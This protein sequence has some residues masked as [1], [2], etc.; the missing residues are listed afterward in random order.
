MPSNRF[1]IASTK[2]LII[3]QRVPFY[4]LM[5]LVGPSILFSFA[6]GFGPDSYQ[7]W[8]DR[9]W[10]NTTN[11]YL[12]SQIP[13]HS[14][15]GPLWRD[16][17]LCGNIWLT[18]L[19]TS[20]LALDIVLGR[21]LHL[22]PFGI[23]VA[24]NLTLYFVAV[25]SMYA[26]LRR[27]L[28]LSMESA[29]AAAAVFGATACWGFA[30]YGVPDL[31]MGVAWL[32][33]LLT[34]MHVVNEASNKT[35]LYP[36]AGLAVLFFVSA[37]HTNMSTQPILVFLLV[38]YA[39]FIFASIRTKL[40]V[41]FG[42][43]LGL[44]LYSPY[45]WAILEAASISQRLHGAGFVTPTLFNPEQWLLQAR[46]MLS[47]AIVG[48]N[49][50]GIY[51]VV[52]LALVLWIYRGPSWVEER[53]A[54]RRVLL[55]ASRMSCFLFLAEL[56]H[57][58]IN[59]LKQS[60]PFM[61]G[62]NATR[63]AIFTCFGVVTLFA[64]TL[65]RSLLYRAET[66]PGSL[67]Q[68]GVRRAVLAVGAVGGLQIAYS[69][70]RMKLVP[71]SIYPQNVVLYVYLFLYSA[72]TFL[73]LALVYREFHGVLTE[74]RSDTRRMSYI[75]LII[76]SVS[77]TTSIH[78][79]RPGVLPSKA[80]MTEGPLTYAQ[81]YAIPDEIMAIK[82]LNDS[83]ERVVDLT[84]LIDP[85]AFGSESEVSVLPLGKLRTL[86][87]YS[88]L[89]P[90]WYGRFVEFGINAGAPD[91]R[92]AAQALPPH[93]GGP[94]GLGSVVQVRIT[95]KT[96][97][98]ALGLL[99]VRYVLAPEGAVL[100]GYKPVMSFDSKGKMLY[101]VS[102]PGRVTPAFISTDVQCFAGDTEALGYINRTG[103]SL[104]QDRAVLVATDAEAASLCHGTERLPIASEERPLEIKTIRGKDRVIVEV[105][106]SQGGILTLADTYYPGWRVLVKG[107]ERSI[108][109]TYTTLRGVVIGPGHQTVEF[110]YAPA[111]FHLLLGLSNA[112]LILLLVAA[113]GVW[114]WEK[115][116][117]QRLEHSAGGNPVKK[118]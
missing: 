74:F 3:N 36:V 43:G 104:L 38:I 53:A 41:I 116:S 95:D 16:E 82:Q 92:N 67:R 84:R 51:L 60:V 52:I 58:D 101:T 26:Y 100:T 79:Y 75:V 66:E 113:G 34:V 31:T 89:L 42:I 20:P 18:S 117:R 45:L 72:V 4:L 65:E 49:Q 108:I 63:V 57:K 27:S 62:W 2:G 14:I 110:I 85:M 48:H 8:E 98:E 71:L 30:W 23:D 9:Y 11:K 78:S 5:G 24:G 19:V 118:L 28:A 93:Q 47:Q 99:D 29:T 55:F 88:I 12:F 17:T 105:L 37:L 86:S 77:L 40:L 94:G 7:Y 107:V 81:R 64:W 39:W 114:V 80:G 70:S 106:N 115:Y 91:R 13:D 83:N 102:E 103:L 73:L 59:F 111:R 22:S 54:N 50:Y 35:V 6:L 76:L 96:N 112:T 15:I 32:P 87:G 1:S 61:G 46:T 90:V 69:A 109:R 33:A 25:V 21:L 44:I 97:F 56:F 10:V 68:D